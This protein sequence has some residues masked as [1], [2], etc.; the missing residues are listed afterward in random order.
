MRKLMGVAG[1]LLVMVAVLGV[2]S[3]KASQGQFELRNQV[4]EDARCYAVS[5]LMQNLDYKILFLCQDILYPGGTSVVNY[6][7]WA[8]PVDGGSPIRLGTLDLGRVELSTKKAFS[9]LFVTK[10]EDARVR[11]PQGQVVMQGGLQRI[12]LL[13]NPNAASL[14]KSELGEPEASPI[15]TPKSS[16][17]NVLRI[18][19]A[20]AFVLLILIVGL[21]FVI[22]RG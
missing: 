12:T 7:V 21:I 16:P 15:P 13:D 8:N 5:G 4:G 17:L 20:V 10:E 18:G 19:G 3:A 6:V 11:S 22:T 9:S 1:V 2:R 14:E